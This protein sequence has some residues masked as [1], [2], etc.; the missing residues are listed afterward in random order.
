V[1]AT[2]LWMNGSDKFMDYAAGIGSM[3]D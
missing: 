2:G 1:V 3:S